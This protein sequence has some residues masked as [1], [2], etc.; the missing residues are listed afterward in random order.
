VSNLVSIDF[1][2][3]VQLI[4]RQAKEVAYEVIDEHLEEYEHKEKT[5]DQTDVEG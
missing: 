1:E 5:P 3:L 4:R 2:K